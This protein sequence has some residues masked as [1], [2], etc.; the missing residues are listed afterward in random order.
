MAQDIKK[1]RN[2]PIGVFDSGVGGLTVAR[3]IMRQ[4]PNEKIVYFGDTARLP[5]G[6]K[7]KD[8]VTRYSRQI[9][10]FLET[11][12]VKAIVVACNTA[13]AYALDSLEKEIKMPIIG[14]VKPGAKV[15]AE[16]T[17][18]GKIGVIGTEG[19]IGSQIYTEYIH[20]INPDARVIGKACPLFCPLVE[21]GLWQ[22]PV[23]DEIASRY[24]TELI[25]IGID[26]L[27][28][29]CTHYPL[30]RSTVGRIMGDKVTLVNPAYETAIELKRLLAAHGLL[31][32]Q[33]PALGDNKYKFYVSDGADKF[34]T[35]A[36]SI[37]KYGILSAKTI[38]I[39]EY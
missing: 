7:S 27:I 10:R 16:V 13:S 35:F 23:T 32:P 19:T 3:E 5:Y 18:N 29:G 28:L 17:Q 39:E 15:A 26:T 30:I 21:E 4:I 33:A 31:N 2:A 25:D 20:N 8:T 37:I 38:N 36:N 22:D 34:K 9:V 14:V 12:E 6:S 24:L 1:L 11:Q